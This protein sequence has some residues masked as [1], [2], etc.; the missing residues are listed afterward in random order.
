[1]K[2]QG[3]DI[4]EIEM[5][6]S[7]AKNSLVRPE[8]ANQW[9]RFAL[10]PYY[11]DPRYIQA[12]FEAEEVRRH[13]KLLTFD[14]MLIDG[15]ELLEGNSRVLAKVQ[16]KYQYVIVDEFQDSNLAQVKLMELVAHPQW[17][18]MVVFDSDQAIYEWR[19]AMPQ[20]AVDFQAKHDAAVVTMGINYRSAPNIIEAAAKCIAHNKNRTDKEITANKEDP[21][22]ITTLWVEDLDEEANVVADEVEQLKNDGMPTGAMYVLYRVNA[23]SRAIEEVFSK[24]KIPHIVLGSTSFYQRKE[25]QD[26]LAYLKLLVDPMD[27]EAGARAIN[28]PFRFISR[29]DVDK[30]K[31]LVGSKRIDFIDAAMEV[32]HDNLRIAERVADFDRLLLDLQA[33]HEARE[34]TPKNEQWTVGNYINE[35]LTRTGYLEYLSQNEGSDTAENSREANVGELIRSA[36]RYKDIAEFLQFVKE[37]IEERKKRKK[38]VKNAVTCMTMHRAKGLEA[39][40]VFLI[41]ANEGIIPHAHSE[42]PY[43]E[44]RRLF[45]V[46]MT[47]A[48]ENLHITAVRKLGMVGNN[49]LRSSRFITEAG[50]ELKSLT[51]TIGSDTVPDLAGDQADAD[52]K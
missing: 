14:D 35:I 24:R 47:R 39:R 45:Y 42:E 8:T 1:M 40:A 37:Q 13:K 15:V 7:L 48:M 30:M 31:H 10:L 5:F 6:I 34:T 46:G 18:L 52:T 44:E 51:P 38:K 29:M 16:E 49:E 9:A 33:K 36:D 4:S 17:N 22:T 20:F 32:A 26:L 23:Q 12:Y 21:G 41:G 3:A 2:W 50:L 11:G 28:R 43:E 27:E 25:V 19:G